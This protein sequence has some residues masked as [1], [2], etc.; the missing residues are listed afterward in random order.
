M[1]YFSTEI[2]LERRA[3]RLVPVVID[4]ANDQCDMTLQTLSHC[5]PPDAV[6]RRVAERLFEAASRTARR[7]R[8]SSDR[9]LHLVGGRT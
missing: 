8:V 4:Y 9:Q 1:D 7:E 2:A 3:G 6:V 5:G